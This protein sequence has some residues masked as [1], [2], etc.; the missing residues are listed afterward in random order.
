MPGSRKVVT[1]VQL[2]CL[3][4]LLCLIL[5][6]NAD[7]MEWHVWIWVQQFP[8]GA[9]IT[10]RVRLAIFG[11]TLMIFI[12]VFIAGSVICMLLMVSVFESY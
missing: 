8:S 7:A 11:S 12:G 9:S 4:S 2:A 6:M 10:P 5:P 1:A 3:D